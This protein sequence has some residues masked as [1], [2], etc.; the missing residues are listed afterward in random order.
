MLIAIFITVVCIILIMLVVKFG[1][2][3]FGIALSSSLILAVILQ[4]GSYPFLNERDKAELLM[5]QIISFPIIFS[6]SLIGVSI[7]MTLCFFYKK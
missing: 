1:F 3:K 4:Y 7:L 6:M 2:K 5:W